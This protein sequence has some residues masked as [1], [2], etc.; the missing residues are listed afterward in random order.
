MQTI[1]G[2]II[3]IYISHTAMCANWDFNEIYKGT[4]F[5]KG[6]RTNHLKNRA[7][8]ENDIKM[9]DWDFRGWVK[10]P[11]KIKRDHLQNVKDY[12]FDVVM[13][14]DLWKNNIKESIKYADKLL[15]FTD[16]VVIPVHFFSKE[17]KGY[18]LAYP[19]ANW[20][21]KNIFPPHEYR[22]QI[23]HILGGSPHSQIRLITTNQIDLKQ[24]PLKFRKVKS[25]DGNQIFNVAIRVG[26]EWFPTKPYWRKPKEKLLTLQIFKN[27]VKKVNNVFKVIL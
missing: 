13:S 3:M 2:K 10:N 23:T 6:A 8:S 1:Q 12:D 4:I 17:I 19:N 27:S 9:L 21:A 7:V 15:K 20:F 18:E 11:E 16:R 14:M 24:N 5:R 26:K 22:D 25:V